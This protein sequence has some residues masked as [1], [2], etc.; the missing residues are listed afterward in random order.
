MARILLLED[1]DDIRDAVGEYLRLADHEVTTATNGRAALEAI[2]SARFDLCLLD[3]RVPGPSGFEVA[4]S[5]RD[6]GVDIPILFLTARDDEA[7]RITGFE[8]GADDYIAKPFSPRELV[9]RVG[10]IL[11]RAGNAAPSPDT[12]ELAFFLAG[13]AL[14]FVATRHHLEVDG[15]RVALTPTEWR[16]F[17]WFVDNPGQVISR[18]ALLETILGYGEALDSRTADTHIKN[19]RAKLGTAAWIE[20]VRGFGYRFAGEERTAP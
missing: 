9:L 19:L 14:R 2:A 10:A 11:R 6:R 5:V 13:S 20:T 18:D 15:R 17:E 4:K 3:V 1:D 8:L 16:I 12:R 7:A